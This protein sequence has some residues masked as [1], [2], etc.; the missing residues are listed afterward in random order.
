MFNKLHRERD[1]EREIEREREK[2]RYRKERERRKETY[3]TVSR[4]INYLSLHNGFSMNM[5]DDVV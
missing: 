4:F 5:F 1:R 2:E 3:N